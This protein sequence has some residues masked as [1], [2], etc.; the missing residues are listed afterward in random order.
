MKIRNLL[1]FG[2]IIGLPTF[3]IYLLVDPSSFNILRYFFSDNN[4]IY[5]FVIST[6]LLLCAHF[7]RAYKTKFLTD[8][9]NPTSIRTHIR[10]LFIGYLFDVL[11]PLR[12]GEIIRAI[13]LGKGT[14]MSSSFML[15][16]I[17]LDRAIDAII[18]GVIIFILIMTGNF[19]T[20]RIHN[21]FLLSSALLILIGLIL[22]IGLI[23]ITYK[24]ARFL[25][26]WHKFTSLFNTNVKDSLR[27]KMWSAIYGLER[28]L[29][30]KLLAKYL[31]LSLIMW[32]IYISAFIPLIS[33]TS[34]RS[35]TSERVTI[36]STS[37]M[38][39]SAPSGPAYIGSYQT[40]VEPFIKAHGNQQS[41]KYT[42]GITWLLQ[43]VPASL[44]GLIFVVRTKEDL[45]RKQH[46][47][48]E[49]LTS[50]KLMREID[51][52]KELS[53]FLDAFFSNNSLSRIMHRF[54]VDKKSKL[55]HY[56]KGGSNAI[57][58]LVHEN[59]EFVVRKITPIQYKYKLK[60]QFDW[61]YD[62]KKLRKIVNVL[63]EETTKDYYKIDLEYN[64]DYIPF[65]DYIHSTPQIKSN[66]ILNNIFGYLFRN[67][68]KFS[69]PRIRMKDLNSYIE[70]RCLNKI[71]QAAESNS[72]LKK[73]IEKK[74]L[75]INGTKY[76]NIPVILDLIEKDK[77][78][79]SIIANYRKCSI[80]GDTTIDN[81][82]ASKLS[83]DFLLIDP[84]DNE[85]EI[86]GPVFDFGRMT[87]SL[88]YG[89]EFLNKDETSVKANGNIIDFEYSLSRN[90]ET[91]Y[92]ELLKLQ[93]KYLTPDEQVSVTF[94]AAVL[95][96]RMLTHRVVINP[97]NAIKYYAV[98]VIAFNDF[99]KEINDYA[100]KEL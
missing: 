78:I 19:G 89:Y 20:Q 60:S 10:A 32:S 14:K 34:P 42:F 66:T 37:Y 25:I 17:I 85:N 77:N 54:E 24:P 94:H 57:T 38:G 64:K 9:I 79:K 11:L 87:Q 93:K 82:L 5:T 28:T 90:Y 74:D 97:A 15:G 43:I 1:I 41:Y 59:N 58:A 63:S 22:I 4:T 23:A 48:V 26:L 52:T 83:D 88:R 27:F 76:S 35:S 75:I 72:D 68:Y 49:Q 62:K 100:N 53:S 21:V 33:H 95:Y 70:N 65:F 7:V 16:L 80:H 47:R 67:I 31:L 8:K 46:K 39:I 40:Y 99:Y 91:L 96:S 81:I 29:K 3:T 36:S 73:L 12:I 45:K 50:D 84:T 56:F 61:L 55:V 2:L 51:M 98:S 71:H 13:V 86:S 30:Y 92:K 18:L 44:L 6:L 69:N